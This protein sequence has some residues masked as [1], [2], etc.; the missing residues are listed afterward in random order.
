MDEL[1]RK[2]LTYGAAEFRR[3]CRIAE[4]RQRGLSDADIEAEIIEENRTAAL[5]FGLTIGAAP[6]IRG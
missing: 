6:E 3:L 4:G 1:Q 2:M 5:H